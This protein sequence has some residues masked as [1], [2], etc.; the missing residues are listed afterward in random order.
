MKI[1]RDSISWPSAEEIVQGKVVC[2]PDCLDEETRFALVAELE[3]Y[4]REPQPLSYGKFD[5]TQCFTAVSSFASTS[6]FL[7]VRDELQTV[8]KEQYSVDP[9]PLSR[10]LELNEL[11]VQCYEEGPIGISP[12]RDGARFK[13]LIAVFVLEGHARFCVC[14]DRE[15]R[16]A[17]P[18]RN[19]PRD[20]LLMRGLGFLGNTGHGPFHFVDRI[21]TKRTS[22]ALRQMAPPW[23]ETA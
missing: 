18:I 20:L 6:L 13:N 12:H 21:M 16:G 17:R 11:V 23:K 7:R 14:D 1:F 10:P 15:G 9:G 8:L 22:F 5:V 19:D 3:H 2:V 4:A